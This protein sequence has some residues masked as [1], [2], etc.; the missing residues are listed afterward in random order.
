MHGACK[1]RIRQ[2]A[3]LRCLNKVGTDKHPK[4]YARSVFMAFSTED[5]EQ[6]SCDWI[7]CPNK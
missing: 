7:L 1:S 2:R 6:H 5:S 4:T 3:E